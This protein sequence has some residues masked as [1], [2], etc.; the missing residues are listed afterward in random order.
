MEIILII[1]KI[2]SIVI[3]VLIAVAFFTVAERK[4][5]GAIQRRRSPNVIGFM[6]LLQALADGLNVEKLII[7]PIKI[8]YKKLKTLQKVGLFLYV[9]F[10]IYRGITFHKIFFLWL[11]LLPFYLFLLQQRRVKGFI[12]IRQRDTRVRLKHYYDDFYFVWVFVNSSLILLV[13]CGLTMYYLDPIKN[14]LLTIGVPFVISLDQFQELTFFYS[15]FV[16]GVNWLTNLYIIWY[17]K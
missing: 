9:I 2:L 1:I 6:G 10:T 11:L 8:S 17:K 4:I 15:L 12:R 7:S 3:P 13:V 16:L 5:M 14:Y